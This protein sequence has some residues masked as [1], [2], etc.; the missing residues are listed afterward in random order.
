[1]TSSGSARLSLIARQVAAG[2]TA[3]RQGSAAS[4]RSD[5]VVNSFLA[6]H[7]DVIYRYALRLTRNHAEAEDLAQDT[8][9]R[10]WRKRHM[11]REP[12][13]AKVW[14]LRI[15]TNLWTDRLR[16]RSGTTKTLDELPESR[17]TAASHG[18]LQQENVAQVLAAVDELP[19]RQRQVLHLVTVEQM[20]QQAAAE[21]LGIST[22]AVKA[23]LSAARK[24]LRERL[25][26]IYEEVCGEKQCETNE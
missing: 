22:A 2:L 21:V 10:G 17:E 20:S 15:A 6:E 19:S 11:L 25:R 26:E 23:S 4:T 14:L 16:R 5:Q 1:M 8:M 24:Q 13:A 7:L 12:E 3:D 18:A 9:L